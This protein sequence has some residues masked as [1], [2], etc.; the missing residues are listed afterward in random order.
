MKNDES[1]IINSLL[2]KI[3]KSSNFNQDIINKFHYL[4]SRLTKKRA[5]TK[6]WGIIYIL[7]SLSKNNY[8][9]MNFDATNKLQQNYINIA[10]NINSNIQNIC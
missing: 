8:K 9:D 6:R 4:Y 10:M 3:S 1:I 2:D 7:N 5:L